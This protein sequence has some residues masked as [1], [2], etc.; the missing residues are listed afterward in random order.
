MLTIVAYAFI[1]AATLFSS[2]DQIVVGI[3]EL[4]VF[5]QR[6]LES[7][8]FIAYQLNVELS[9]NVQLHNF[10]FKNLDDFLVQWLVFIS[11]YTMTGFDSFLYCHILDDIFFKFCKFKNSKEIGIKSGTRI[12]VYRKIFVPL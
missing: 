7:L 8:W 4:T 9:F 2:H 5:C 1:K 6:S 10:I 12:S 3:T 11:P